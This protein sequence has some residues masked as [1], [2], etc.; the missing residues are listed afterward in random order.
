M[1]KLFAV[2]PRWRGEHA[3]ASINSRAMSGL[4]P[5]ARGTREPKIF[6]LWDCRFIPAGAG[7]TS[8]WDT[9]LNSKTVYPRW[10]GEHTSSPIQSFTCSGLSPLRCCNY[11]VVFRKFV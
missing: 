2:Y 1:V 10:R 11:F 8:E 5:L 9:G 3:Q 6:A 7:N 4:S